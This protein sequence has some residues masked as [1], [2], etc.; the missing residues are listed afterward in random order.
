M[1]LAQVYPRR[2]GKI[3]S[4]S[5]LAKHFSGWG[6]S[7]EVIEGPNG[8]VS[9]SPKGLALDVVIEIHSKR[10]Q[11]RTLKLLQ[12]H[13]LHITDDGEITFRL[14]LSADLLSLALIGIPVSR[15]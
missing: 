15:K 8:Y 11:E 2:L 6:S 13:S 5:K 3:K 14:P 12:D 9:M 4:A 1:T 7:F 10:V